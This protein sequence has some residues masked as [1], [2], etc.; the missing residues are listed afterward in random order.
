MI[1][2]EIMGLKFGDFFSEFGGV[3]E[4]VFLWKWQGLERLG[5]QHDFFSKNS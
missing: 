5:I 2:D 3:G 4:V 1:Y